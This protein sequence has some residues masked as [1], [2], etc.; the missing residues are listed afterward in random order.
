MESNKNKKITIAGAGI[1][2]LTAGINLA[3]AGFDTII[4]EQHGEIG[5]RFGNDFQGIEN[6]T[7]DEDVYVFLNRINIESNFPT[8]SQKNIEIWL[9][10]GKR[11]SLNT[12]KT[13]FYLV[14]RGTDLDT[15]DQ[16]LLKQAKSLKS[17][18]IVFNSPI[19]DYSTID[20][21]ATGP[22]FRDRY[23]DGIV[24]GYKFQTSHPDLVA[25][26]LNDNFAPD[27]YGYCIIIR[28]IGVIT[29]VL[30]RDYEKINEYRENLVHYVKKQIN[31]DIDI[32]SPHL[33]GGVGNY[34][35][36]RVPPDRK[37]Y[38]GEAGGFQDGFWG[39]GIR[40]AMNTGYIAAQSI[41][42]GF[43][44]YEAISQQVTPL[45][46]ASIVNRYLYRLLN[47]P[48]YGFVA[49][50]LHFFKNP[51]ELLGTN[52][53]FSAL[54]RILFPLANFSLRHNTQDPRLL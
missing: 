50:M 4:Y 12:N 31:I 32:N 9:D 3:K 23:T 37:I 21:V 2:G 28:G 19:K 30:F 41:I 11:E 20:I 5:R 34:F 33:Y 39:F 40:S 25:L 1:S 48:S 46:K 18:Q 8:W 10:G 51:E 15:L 7:S 42:K 44:Y 47:N 45:I 38:V 24:S 52:Y 14:K 6:W 29:T 27:G 54:K 17:L 36:A 43:D 49:K 26:I 16:N 35:L 22:C 13:P 53:Q